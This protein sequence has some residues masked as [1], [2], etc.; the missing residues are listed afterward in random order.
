MLLSGNIFCSPRPGAVRAGTSN[1]SAQDDFENWTIDVPF[2]TYTRLLD[3]FK[4]L[5]CLASSLLQCSGAQFSYLST[6]GVRCVP[7][8]P[9]ALTHGAASAGARWVHMGALWLSA[10][11]LW[12]VPAVLGQCLHLHKWI[13]SGLW[14]VW[15][16]SAGLAVLRCS[17]GSRWAPWKPRFVWKQNLF[18]P[19]HKYLIPEG[20]HHCFWGGMLPHG[21]KQQSRHQGG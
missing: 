11:V 10:G 17:S 16:G 14:S 15:S 2:R 8:D 6:P 13:Q 9:A 18:C 1:S 12:A 21:R 7:Q 20:Y 19:L 5:F 4:K 3:S